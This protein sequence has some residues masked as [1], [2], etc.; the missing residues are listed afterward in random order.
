MPF[1]SF[2]GIVSG[3][4]GGGGGGGDGGGGGGGGTTVDAYTKTESD[5]KYRLIVD[6]YT[7][8]ESDSKYLQAVTSTTTPGGTSLVKAADTLKALK[9][10]N[11]TL[12]TTTDFVTIEARDSYTKIET[13]NSFRTKADSYSK[14]E[15][16]TKTEADNGFRTKADSYNKTEV[17]SKTE[18]DGLY[19]WKSAFVDTP[20]SNLVWTENVGYEMTINTIK[21]YTPYRVPPK[22]AG[23]SLN[24]VLRFRQDDMVFRLGETWLYNG[25]GGQLAVTMLVADNPTAGKRIYVR[26]W[27]G[28][29]AENLIWAAPTLPGSFLYPSKKIASYSPVKIE[30]HVFDIYIYAIWETII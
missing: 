25:S 16:Y 9:G 19:L 26:D 7:K 23:E 17:Y 27:D 8:T 5:G 13:D 6:S 3:G 2:P 10:T 29:F 4:G 22:P 1:G 21:P 12:T 20:T 18:S 30:Y 14:T 15:T 24:L 11:C 28:T